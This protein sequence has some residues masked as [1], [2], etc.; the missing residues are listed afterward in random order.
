MQNSEIQ[1]QV[2]LNIVIIN[3]MKNGYTL[4]E[5]LV[6]IVAF[7]VISIVASETIILTLRGTYKADA[8]SKVRQN[9]DYAMSS[10]ERQIRGAQSI[11]SLCDNKAYPQIDFIDQNSNPVSFACVNINQTGQD[12]SISSSSGTITANNL[13]ISQCSFTC[14]Q[15]SGGSPPSVLISITAKDTSGQN[16]AVSAETQVTLRSY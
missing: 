3:K 10:M 16:A 2:Y 15:S 7:A 8:I 12:S 6:V 9:V 14:L 4:V 1:L 5:L 13:T 11:T